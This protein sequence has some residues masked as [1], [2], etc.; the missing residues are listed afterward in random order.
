[1]HTVLECL[2]VLETELPCRLSQRLMLLKMTGGSF[3]EATTNIASHFQDSQFS[4]A[5]LG[6]LPVIFNVI[7]YYDRQEGMQLCL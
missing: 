7:K 5:S 2:T 3:S 4:V 6:L 1:M